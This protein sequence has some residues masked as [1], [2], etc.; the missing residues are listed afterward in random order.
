M[1]WLRLY[2]SMSEVGKRPRHRDFHTISESTKQVSQ[3]KE[4]DKKAGFSFTKKL[5]G[6]WH[7]GHLAANLTH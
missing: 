3:K 1:H 6:I 7:D 2:E 5:V 4:K